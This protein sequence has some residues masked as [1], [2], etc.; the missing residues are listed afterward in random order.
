V[1]RRLNAPGHAPP[2]QVAWLVRSLII[3]PCCLCR[4][5]RSVI[6]DTAVTIAS[7]VPPRPETA[8]KLRLLRNIQALTMAQDFH[9]GR[10]IHDLFELLW[11][12]RRLCGPRTTDRS[13]A[14][15]TGL[16]WLSTAAASG[17]R[18]PG[19][20]SPAGTAAG[21]LAAPP[22]ISRRGRYL[23]AR[24]VSRRAARY[25]AAPPG[26]SPRRPVPQGASGTSP[27]R[28]V[29]QGAS[30]TSPRRPVPQG[31]SGTSPRRPV[32]QGASSTSRRVWYLKA[33]PVPRLAARGTRSVPLRATT[34]VQLKKKVF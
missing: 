32:P 15:S 10:I 34:A 5:P 17:E 31:A 26:T 28:P 19:R 8:R 24:P 23:K 30:G 11:Q 20:Q 14:G 21:S 27:R 6:L 13:G 12:M 22:G 2:E 16:G 29:P 4:D 3:A 33:R 1:S 9:L 7:P 18:L 25:L